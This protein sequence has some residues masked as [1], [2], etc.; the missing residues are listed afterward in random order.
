MART[1]SDATRFTATGP[2]AS[3]SPSFGSNPLPN[4]SP[5]N[6]TAPLGTRIDFGSAP[7]NETSQQKIARLRAASALARHGKESPFD[8]LVRVGRVWADRA[9]R[10]TAL[11]LIGLTV[12]VGC[13]ATAGIT[14][15]L[16]HNRRRRGEWLAEQQA[17]LARATGEARGAMERGT[18]TEE[19]VLLVNRQRAAEEAAEERARRPGVVKRVKGWL[20]SDLSGEEVKGGRLGV[21]GAG[22]GERGAGEVVGSEVE[23]QK[24]DRSVLQAVE[25][26]LDANRRQ[27][28]KVE[29]VMRPFGGPLDQQAQ[30]YVN[31]A[32]GSSRSLMDWV[33]RR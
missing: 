5:T 20:F 27:G 24:H 14:D 7:A 8:A 3:S 4:P 22:A 13:V 28:E 11:G 19:Q 30:L 9:H 1:P 32:S 21:F 16:L 23:G 29:E 18:A 6:T 2:Y 26:R 12:V 17:R 10:V 31:T 15:M 25:E 33:T